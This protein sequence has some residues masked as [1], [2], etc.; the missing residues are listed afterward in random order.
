M[1]A[2]NSI[3]EIRKRL[4]VRE[5]PLDIL[6]PAQIAVQ[7]IDAGYSPHTAANAAEIAWSVA[8]TL[9]TGRSVPP[10]WGT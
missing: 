5:H 9:R 4:R 8:A 2:I 1:T 3:A 10:M 7:L 6:T